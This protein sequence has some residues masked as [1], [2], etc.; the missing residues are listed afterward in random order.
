MATAL[1][2]EYRVRKNFAKIPKIIDIP[3][4]IEMQKESYNQFLQWDVSPALRADRGLQ[5]VFQ[6]RLSHRG[7]QRNGLSRFRSVQFGGGQVR[8]GGM[9]G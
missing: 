3:N 6:E 7:L 5:E 4:L 2:H 1:T 8:C 9:P